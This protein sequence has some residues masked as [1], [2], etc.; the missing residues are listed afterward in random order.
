MDSTENGD[1]LS[2]TNQTLQVF[3]FFFFFLVMNHVKNIEKTNIVWPKHPVCIMHLRLIF[4]YERFNIENNF[5]KI[6]YRL[7]SKKF[8]E[9]Y[10]KIKI[11]IY[12]NNDDY[13]I[14]LHL[15]LSTFCFFCFLYV[16]P[17]AAHMHCWLSAIALFVPFLL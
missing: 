6:G 16:E 4:I 8:L 2:L 10:I 15:F 17:I 14:I 5:S 11:K 7:Q 1:I 3:F 9:N 12:N 13:L